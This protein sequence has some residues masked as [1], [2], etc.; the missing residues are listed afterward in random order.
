VGF[1][2]YHPS[3]LLFIFFAVNFESAIN[4]DKGSGMSISW[5]K[6][7]SNTT[8]MIKG[9]FLFGLQNVLLIISKQPGVGSLI[10]DLVIRFLFP[11]LVGPSVAF[12]VKSM[13]E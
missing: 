2:F 12:G 10:R 13:L 7:I 5:D 1:C 9:K 4:S 3:S 11:S 6:W 8:Y